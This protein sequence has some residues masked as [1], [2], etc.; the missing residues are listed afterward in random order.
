MSRVA[1]VIRTTLL[2]C[3][4]TFVVGEIALRGY[5]SIR[6]SFIFY[7][8][9]YDR[10][11][12]APGALDNGLPLNSGGF[13][14]V[15]SAAT[16]GERCRIVA[17][18]DSFAYGVVPYEDNYLTVLESEL[19]RRGRPTEVVNMGIP[20]IGPADYLSLMVAEG[21]DRDPDIVL[22][23]FCLGNDFRDSLRSARRDKAIWENSYVATLLHFVTVIRPRYQGSNV[24]GREP[25][26]DAV[27][28]FSKQQY[29]EVMARRSQIYRAD[30]PDFDAA[31]EQA[32]GDIGR[33]QRICERRGI[34]LAVAVA[35]EEIQLDRDLQRELGETFAEYREGPLDFL[36]PYRL[37]VETLRKS[38]IEVIDL[39]DAFSA[40]HRADRPLYKPRNTHWNIAG[41]RLAA[42]VIAAQIA[43]G[44]PCS[45]H[46]PRGMH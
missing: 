7:D 6:P 1:Q 45:G 14:D 27:P 41:N 10:F 42:E 34:G 9:S 22:V 33:I 31:F 23:T 40:Q 5:N 2:I 25:Y 19:A 13:R 37:L 11:R 21:L 44:E 32:V 18:G 43:A 8:D 35:P 38:G 24:Y 12:R 4:I 15:E 20:G 3:A 29:L 26:S 30:W 28:T 16:K 17:L 39:L 36:R 46:A